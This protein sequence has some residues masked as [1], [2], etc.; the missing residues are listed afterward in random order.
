MG[1][2]HIIWTIYIIIHLLI[3]CLT[4]YFFWTRTPH[5]PKRRISPLE[6]LPLEVLNNI[7]CHL[8]PASI[9]LLRHTCTYMA[10][11]AGYEATDTLRRLVQADP[12]QN[13]MLLRLM[14]ASVPSLV[15][16]ISSVCNLCKTLHARSWFEPLEIYKPATVRRC[17]VAYICDHGNI[18][19]T[20]C[21]QISLKTRPSQKYSLHPNAK[22]SF[23]PHGLRP[24]DSSCRS[25]YKMRKGQ[26]RLE[27]GATGCAVRAF[28]L[29]PWAA[30]PRL[31]PL[32]KDL[33]SDKPAVT[34]STDYV[35]LDIQL[36]LHRRVSDC[37]DQSLAEGPMTDWAARVNKRGWLVRC[38]RC[39]LHV[40]SG[41]DGAFISVQTWREYGDGTDPLDAR[42]LAHAR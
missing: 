24:Q 5:V 8:P 4:G 10:R 17:R 22:S 6:Q 36:C 18:T 20:Q 33:H 25:G 31:L 41:R 14:E 32:R 40:W 12:D 35:N 30:F 26:I 29:F 19:L 28:Y 21:R 27:S 2:I 7:V 23:E 38:L 11:C 34:T 37:L 16:S 39:S 3:S 1:S 9:L 15:S 13:L 42:W